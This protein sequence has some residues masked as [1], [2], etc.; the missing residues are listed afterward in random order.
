[1]GRIPK[2]SAISPHGAAHMQRAGCEGKNPF[3]SA[4]SKD[5][6]HVARCGRAFPTANMKAHVLNR[7][8]VRQR[9]PLYRILR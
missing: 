2:E 6:A 8:H 3:P 4:F 1:M 5:I 9:G 7:C